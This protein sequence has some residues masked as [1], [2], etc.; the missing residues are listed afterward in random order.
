M[1]LH[2][3]PT[4]RVLLVALGQSNWQGAA[5]SE[6]GGAPERYTSLYT[7]WRDPLPGCNNRGQGG[8]CFPLLID[9]SWERGAKLDVWNG[10]IGGARV[11]DYCGLVGSTPTG[12]ATTLPASQGYMSPCV[13]SG[14]T[15]AAVEGQGDFDPWGLLARAR[16]YAQQMAGKYDAIVSYWVNGESDAGT[17]HATYAAG[18]QSVADYMLASGVDRHIIGLTCMHGAGT[19][20]QYDTLTTGVS[21]AVSNLQAAGKPVS[22]GHSMYAVYRTAPPLY[23][24]PGT[25]TY[26]HM[27]LRGQRRQAIETDA[28]LAAL[29]Y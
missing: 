10:A 21:L 8:S 7:G 26:T 9:L 1:P 11:F 28:V 22:Q 23:P 2:I 14:G 17:G 15:V 6:S 5:R 3:T 16:A 12:G 20:T 13:L 4:R 27:T 25:T 18:L 19:T 29:G 24:E